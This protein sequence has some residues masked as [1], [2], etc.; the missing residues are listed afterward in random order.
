MLDIA[1]RNQNTVNFYQLRIGVI[2]I[3]VC[4]ETFLSFIFSYFLNFKKIE[5]SHF[6]YDFKNRNVYFYLACH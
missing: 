1:D 3:F 5:L 2:F 4:N 6:K